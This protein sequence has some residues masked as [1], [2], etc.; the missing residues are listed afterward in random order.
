M[1]STLAHWLMWWAMQIKKNK[2]IFLIQKMKP[3]KKELVPFDRQRLS[4]IAKTSSICVILL[5]CL[6]ASLWIITFGI[7]KRNHC[8]FKVPNA[9]IRNMLMNLA[10]EFGN[11]YINNYTIFSFSAFYI[12]HCSVIA[13]SLSM[14]KRHADHA[15]KLYK[16]LLQSFEGV[17]ETLSPFILFL[18]VRIFSGFFMSLYALLYA[19]RVQNVPI[20]IMRFVELSVN[21]TLMINI[22][23]SADHA[24]RKADQFRLSLYE[25]RQ[26]SSSMEGKYDRFVEDSKYLKLT[27]WGVFT[28]QKPLLLG[29]V[30]WIFTYTTVLL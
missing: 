15:F 21:A 20:P 28:I 6:Y 14:R 16:T 8:P 29:V 11:E 23:L 12:L 19:V 22:V 30:A 25:Y 7:S 26:V 27:A 18:F 17:E 9:D 4:K 13:N 3:F 24:Q 5:S 1:T 10:Y 2:F